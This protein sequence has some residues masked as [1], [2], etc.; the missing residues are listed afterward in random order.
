MAEKSIL[1]VDDEDG[2]RRLAERILKRLGYPVLTASNGA[3]ALEVYA[4]KRA[5][6]ALVIMDISMPEMSG[7]D[8]MRKMRAIDPAVR[9]VLSSGFDVDQSG[10]EPGEISGFMEKPYQLAQLTE[11]LARVAP[12]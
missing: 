12:R 6:I 7:V 5:E 11:L 4:A 9:V 1:V 2:V 3:E 10:V 8:C